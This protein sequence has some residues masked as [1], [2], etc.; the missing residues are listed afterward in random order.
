MNEST[1]A[2]PSS[3][4]IL[5][6]VYN[7]WCALT[8]LIPAIDQA[9]ASTDCRAQLL[10]I[11]DGSQTPPPEHWPQ[12]LVHIYRIQVIPLRRNLG[13]Q[14]AIAIGLACA[15]DASPGQPIL[16]M[17]GDG[18]D[19]PADIPALLAAYKTH[20]ADAVIFAAR[21][22][23]S[24]SAVFIAGYHLFRLLHRLL[25][26]FDVRVGNFSLIPPKHLQALMV[27]GELWNHYAAAVFKL[28][29]PRRLVPTDR[30][31]RLHGNSKMNLPALVRHGLSALSVHS[32]TISARLM[33]IAGLATIMAVLA[34]ALLLPVAMICGLSV[35]WM[36]LAATCVGLIVLTQ[37]DAVV[38]LFAFLTLATR[39]SPSFLPI[40]DYQWFLLDSQNTPSADNTVTNDD[41]QSVSR[42][43][44]Q[45]NGRDMR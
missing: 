8:E 42:S 5:I 14:R 37:V 29:V 23:R 38:V 20:Q 24:E 9:L 41:D 28:K 1:T 33:V 45:S 18:E 15:W 19:R 12:P 31:R 22:R 44:A 25:V 17:D 7:D 43:S 4:T 36:A 26:G 3:L 16:V 11:N 34:I 35:L 10:V 30:G 40:R 32:D 2:N 13:H 6:P 27:A 21:R 39:E